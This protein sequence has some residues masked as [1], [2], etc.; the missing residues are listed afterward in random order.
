MNAISDHTDSSFLGT[1]GIIHYEFVPQDQANKHATCF[2][3]HK[4][5]QLLNETSE[6]CTMMMSSYTALSGKV[7]GHNR[8]TRV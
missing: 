3:S 7:S 4:K 6:F 2:G 5:D 1:K 8:N